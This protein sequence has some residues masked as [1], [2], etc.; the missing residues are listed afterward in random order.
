VKMTK[1]AWLKLA[2]I[3]LVLAAMACLDGIGCS[4]DECGQ[5]GLETG[6]QTLNP[7]LTRWQ[8]DAPGA[9]KDCHAD[10]HLKVYW[11][12]EL[13]Q[14]NPNALSPYSDSSDMYYDFRASEGSFVLFPLPPTQKEFNG[15]YHW[16]WRQNIGAKNEANNPTTYQIQ[17]WCNGLSRLEA[18]PD[19]PDWWDIKVEGTI[20]YSKYHES[21]F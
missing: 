10:F 15:K 16:E 6:S 12:N 19:K 11:A 18:P 5:D 9:N 2:A 8:L 21:A 1:T 20:I 4:C 13:R 3:V 14:T 17:V 7:R